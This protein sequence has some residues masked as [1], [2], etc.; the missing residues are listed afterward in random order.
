MDS[1]TALLNPL[2]PRLVHFPIALVIS[3]MGIE[4]S[5]LL[6][7]KDSW[8]KAAWL[9]FVAAVISMPMV[10]LS[11]LYE[12]NRLHLHHPVLNEHRTY[13]FLGGGVSLAGMLFLWFIRARK[14][15]IF[16]MVFFAVLVVSSV[17]LTLAAYEG[18]RMVYEYGVGTNQ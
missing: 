16:P 11:G 3:A 17:L 5:G 4:A 14:N 1:L 2:H 10:I 18:G 13:A 15:T 12:A 9:M 6:L 8:C 7:K